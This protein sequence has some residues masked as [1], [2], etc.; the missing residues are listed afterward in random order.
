MTALLESPWP[1]IVVGVMAAGLLGVAYH[2]TGNPRLRWAMAG[3]LAAVLLLLLVEWLVVTDREAIADTLEDVAVALETND[4]DAVLAYLA[5][6]GDRIRLDA[7]RYLPAFEIS[8]ANVG[9]DL[10]VVVN[11]VTNPRTAR[12]TFTGRISGASRNLAERSPYENFVR[13]F[14][15]RLREDEDRWLITDYDMGGLH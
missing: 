13:P 3:T 1:A 11:R 15:L 7:Q 8:D 4:L 5:P 10:E 2:N 6:E 12:V 14:T 9:G